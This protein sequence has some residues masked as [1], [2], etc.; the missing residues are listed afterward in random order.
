M[1]ETKADDP[2]QASTEAA[3]YKVG[4]CRPPLANRFRPGQSGNPR[5]RPKGARNLRTVM[6]AALAEMVEIKERTTA[7][8]ASACWRRR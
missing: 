4:Y 6:A 5:G 7:R 1:T 3:E 8:A 2:A